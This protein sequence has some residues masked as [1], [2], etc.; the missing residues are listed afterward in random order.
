MRGEDII[1][2]SACL[3]LLFVCEIEQGLPAASDKKSPELDLDTITLKLIASEA[4]MLSNPYE[5][6]LVVRGVIG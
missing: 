6:F 4:I 2:Q 1:K 3:C 5:R